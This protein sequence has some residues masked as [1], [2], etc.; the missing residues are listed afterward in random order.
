MIGKA[1]CVDAVNAVASRTIS[2]FSRKQGGAL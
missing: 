1:N 2:G